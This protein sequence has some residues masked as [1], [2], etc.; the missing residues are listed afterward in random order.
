V[1]DVRDKGLIQKNPFIIKGVKSRADA[2][3]QAKEGLESVGLLK[4]TRFAAQQQDEPD[5]T[6]LN[7]YI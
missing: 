5:R 4:F 6:M 2:L 7:S 1:A 3:K